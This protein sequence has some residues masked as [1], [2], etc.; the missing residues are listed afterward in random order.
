[1]LVPENNHS[2]ICHL[3]IFSFQPKFIHN[4]LFSCD[5]RSLLSS[6]VSNPRFDM[7]VIARV[8]LQLI[9]RR[10]THHPS[11]T[12]AKQF[13]EKALQFTVY[14]ILLWS[15]IS[16]VQFI[17]IFT[18]TFFSS[19]PEPLWSW[20][21]GH[22]RLV[23]IMNTCLNCGDNECT[24]LMEQRSVRTR[25]NGSAARYQ[26]NKRNYS[27]STFQTARFQFI[28]SQG[29]CAI[30]EKLKPFSTQYYSKFKLETMCN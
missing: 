2:F 17:W 5:G 21:I 14:A 6:T 26:I 10:N 19:V 7:N 16:S 29:Y 18:P 24:S 8:V 25:V 11:T 20:S 12:K 1:M 4:I 13:C 22:V 15:Q 23:F 27:I 9:V 30:Y 3:M 28:R